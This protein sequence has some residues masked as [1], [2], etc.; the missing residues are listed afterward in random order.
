VIIADGAVTTEPA[1]YAAT[2]KYSDLPEGGALKPCDRSST[3]WVARWAAC[4]AAPAI[5]IADSSLGAFTGQPSATL[6]G[7]GR[8]AGCAAC[9]TD[10][11]SGVEYI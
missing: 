9:G 4:W 6:I 3:S 7:R 5:T 8:K 1:G 2:A 10:Q 11:L